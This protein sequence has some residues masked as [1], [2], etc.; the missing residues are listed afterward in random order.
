[1]TP[2]E[3]NYNIYNKELL[4]IITALKEWRAFL[5]GTVEPF[6][7][8][9]DY[10]NLTGFLIIKE[11]NQRQVKWAEILSKYYFKIKHISRTDNT[12]ADILSRKA[13]LQGNKKPLGAIL[14]LDKDR[15]VRYNH[16][17]LVG[18]HKAP[19]SL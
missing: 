14:R 12:R 16:P 19:Q 17:Q 4:A 8:K 10:K 11:L 18:I 15:R 9:T 5:Q 7:I 13:E 2:L 1:M 6:I 3:L